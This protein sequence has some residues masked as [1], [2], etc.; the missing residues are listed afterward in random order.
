MSK[1][2]K[3]SSLLFLIGLLFAS[4]ISDS[5]QQDE[6]IYTIPPELTNSLPAQ[7]RTPVKEIT[8]T[9]LFTPTLQRSTAEVIRELTPVSN[10]QFS[11][12]AIVN[13]DDG[14]ILYTRNTVAYS[15]Y[16]SF[17]GNRLFIMSSM[18]QDIAILDTCIYNTYS[19]EIPVSWKDDGS[20]VVVG[21]T[22]KLVFH[23]LR[24]PEFFRLIALDFSE[25]PVNMQSPTPEIDL[26]NECSLI[27]H[28]TWMK[29]ENKI[30]LICG[31]NARDTEK[32]FCNVDFNFG[33]KESY[34]GNKYL[35]V[36]TEE[37][38]CT[39]LSDAFDDEIVY[40]YALKRSPVNDDI[41]FSYRNN[42][43][44]D[45][46]YIFDE[47]TMQLDYLF[48]EVGV[49]W[50]PDG[51]RIA[52]INHSYEAGRSRCLL[53]Y[54]LE[55]KQVKYLY[56]PVERLSDLDYVR[57]LQVDIGADYSPDGK[58]II[59]VANRDYIDSTHLG[60]YRLNLE[61]NEICLLTVWGDGD[62]KNPNWIPLCES[63]SQ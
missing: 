58:Y 15:P 41:L 34:L 38:Q 60:I 61:T 49:A 28:L 46:T 10:T 57:S 56:C 51:K 5:T 48:P 30:F 23:D 12:D 19:D 22:N 8:A 62:A 44:E 2:L 54:N 1:Y 33:S 31:E 13:V 35:T 4:C 18:G 9:R 25:N 11:S 42:K 39:K 50:S 40:V 27:F 36:E 55:T 47:N 6:L 43:D 52:M 21:C 29:S 20:L 16:T 45:Q 59:F 3:I 37:M 32:K 24:D 17:A 53:E 26:S 7:T 63:C 14:Y